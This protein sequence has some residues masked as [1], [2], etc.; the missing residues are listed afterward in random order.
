MRKGRLEVKRLIKSSLDKV[1][2]RFVALL[3]KN[4]PPFIRR[5]DKGKVI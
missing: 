3:L 2:H 1:N 4:Y 5:E